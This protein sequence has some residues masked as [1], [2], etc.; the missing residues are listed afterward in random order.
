MSFFCNSGHRGKRSCSCGCS[1]DCCVQEIKCACECP[2]VTETAVS[3]E[4]VVA[5]TVTPGPQT[6]RALLNTVLDSCCVTD[7]VCRELTF[8]A[9]EI[10]PCSVEVG[11]SFDV[12]IR[13]D[14]T[15]REVTRNKDNCVCVSTV[16]YTIPVRIFIDESGCGCAC[17]R[18]LDR[19]ITVIRSAR[20]CC[21]AN[22]T[23]TTF[24]SQVIAASAVVSEVCANRVTITLCLLFRSCLQQTVLREYTWTATP[25]CESPNCHDAR[26]NLLDSCD[27]VCG[28]TAGFTCPSC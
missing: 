24:N 25:V 17:T 6:V 4:T 1:T 7:D 19:D 10:D 23:L 16:R 9:E 11:T 3:A 21:T 2:T 18:C 12:D 13:D 26:N 5:G 27:T 28:C 8:S 22:S 14:I 15:F 20:L